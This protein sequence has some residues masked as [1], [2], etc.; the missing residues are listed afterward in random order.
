MEVVLEDNGMPIFKQLIGIINAHIKTGKLKVGDRLPSELTLAPILDVNEQTIRRAY[1]ALRSAGV[2][3]G[4]LG[5]G[6]YVIENKN[7]AKELAYH[8]NEMFNSVQ[9]LLVEAKLRNVE[10]DALTTMMIALHNGATRKQAIELAAKSRS[11]KR[12]VPMQN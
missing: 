5:K 4:R 6:T 9:L 1:A 8:L 11:Q 12:E 2:L 3:K 10:A 7:P